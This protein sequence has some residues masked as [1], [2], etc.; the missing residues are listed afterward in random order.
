MS[1]YHFDFNHQRAK[2]QKEGPLFTI[3]LSPSDDNG[4][5]D[6]APDYDE[7]AAS[8]VPLDIMHAWRHGS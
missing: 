3:W 2:L 8:E 4:R 7:V 5:Y 6:A 1:T